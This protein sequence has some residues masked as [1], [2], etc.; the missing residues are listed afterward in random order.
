MSVHAP[1]TISPDPTGRSRFWWLGALSLVVL[2]ALGGTLSAPLVR[3]ERT[4]TLSVDGLVM[5]VLTAH[6]TVDALLDEL[7]VVLAPGDRIEPQVTAAL[8][9]SVAIA[10]EKARPAVIQA[11]GQE[12]QVATHALTVAQALSEAGVAL[13]PHDDLSL[14]GQ[15]VQADALLPPKWAQLDLPQLGQQ[16]APVHIS[17]HRASAVTIR[18]GS[19]TKTIYTTS[20]TVADALWEAGVVTY[21]GDIVRPALAELVQ[22]GL[23][24]EVVRSKPV[25][26]VSQE[27]VI[28]TRTLGATVGEALAQEGVN[29][30]GKDYSEPAAEMALAAGQQIQVSRVVEDWVVE[31]EVIPYETLSRPSETLEL[32]QQY[33]EQSGRDGLRKRRYRVTYVNGQPT[34]QVLEREWVAEEPQPRVLVYG[35]KIVVRE[36]QT[37]EGTLRYWR[38]FRVLATSYT[39]A[40]SGKTRDHPEF[41]ITFL[42]WRARRGIV[43]VDPKTIPLTTN[44]YVPGYGLGVAGDTG[45]KIKGLR[46]DLCYEEA[47]Y[48]PWYRWVDIYLLEPAPA[49]SRIS[50]TLPTWPRE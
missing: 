4:V 33:V 2:G 49:R 30:A 1:K 41:G 24:I 29:L 5:E 44:M 37:A 28:K 46:I 27:G 48:V 9:D 40:S 50:W 43:A 25:V 14:N 18:D 35:T 31:A 12:L 39:A 32:D 42:G 7:G 20:G 6:T 22:D 23:E 16:P 26:I 13:S 11:D 47:S 8:A 45:G 38:H 15:P 36:L 34:S 21:L 17:V 19:L 3:A 10:V